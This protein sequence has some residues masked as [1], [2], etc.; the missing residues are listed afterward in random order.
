[1]PSDA[2]VLIHA[3]PIAVL[4]EKLWRVLDMSSLDIIIYQIWHEI[5]W[6]KLCVKIFGVGFPSSI[7]YFWTSLQGI[8]FPKIFRMFL[9]RSFPGPTPKLFQTRSHWIPLDPE[10][11][12]HHSSTIRPF[13]ASQGCL[14]PSL[15]S[16]LPPVRVSL[17]EGACFEGLQVIIGKKW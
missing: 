17:G 7:L 10:F 6:P 8:E 5:W 12:A 3:H 4:M 11:S 16:Q 13:P 1:M 14:V 9:Q 15:Y 2:H